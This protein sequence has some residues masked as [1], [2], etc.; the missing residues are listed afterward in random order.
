M[1]AGTTH[2]YSNS[3]NIYLTLTMLYAAYSFE[4]YKQELDEAI[5]QFCNNVTW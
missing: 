1:S 2:L 4:I 5:N 3:L